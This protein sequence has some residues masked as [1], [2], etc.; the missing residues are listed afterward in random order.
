MACQ[1]FPSMHAPLQSRM[2]LAEQH[3][4]PFCCSSQQCCMLLWGLDHLAAQR[5]PAR[6]ASDTLLS[7]S[8]PWQGQDKAGACGDTAAGKGSAFC[9][10]Q[11]AALGPTFFL[12]WDQKKL[13]SLCSPCCSMA[14]HHHCSQHGLWVSGFSNMS[15]CREA[16]HG[17]DGDRQHE[18]DSM[19]DHQRKLW[20]HW[21]SNFRNLCPQH[22]TLL[23]LFLPQTDDSFGGG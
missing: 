15:W 2:A 8:S 19:R 23:P 7:N 17:G 14:W 1:C 5:D 12:E 13:A 3:P 11:G 22:S 18:E 16:P 4:M 21:E 9:L 20:R 6:P 10:H